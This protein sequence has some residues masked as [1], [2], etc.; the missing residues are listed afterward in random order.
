MYDTILEAAEVPIDPTTGVRR[1][2]GGDGNPFGLRGIGLKAL[3]SLRL[4]KGYRDMRHDM[5]NCDSI[6]E[7]G[8]G[9]TCDF[10]KKAKYG[11]KFVGQS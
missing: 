3:A 1:A 8:L 10:D 2:T 6:L 5:D 7:C 9:F 4:E 11:Y